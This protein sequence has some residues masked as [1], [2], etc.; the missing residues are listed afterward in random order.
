[1]SD[2]TT[3]AGA[4]HACRPGLGLGATAL[5]L[6]ACALNPY[7]PNTRPYPAPSGASTPHQR[8]EYAL[9]YAD[10]TYDAYSAKLVEEQ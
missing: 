9:A 2:A 10:R 4:G 3:P 7:I 6:S 1:M 8:L 5:L